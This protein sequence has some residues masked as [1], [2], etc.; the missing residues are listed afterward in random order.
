MEIG[1]VSDLGLDD[2][3]SN[4]LCREISFEEILLDETVAQGD[5]WVLR[6]TLQSVGGINYRLEAKKNYELLIRIAQKYKVLQT[7]WE[8]FR[9]NLPETGEKREE[10]WVCLKAETG[11]FGMQES[12]KTDCYLIGRYKEK[13]LSMGS[14]DEAV[15]SV[16]SAGG[17]AA[18]QYLE[19]MLTRTKE[20]Y[21]I[22]DCTQPILIYKGNDICYHMLDIFAKELGKALEEM[23]QRV[24][25]FDFSERQ[26]E[27]LIA[28]KERRFKAVAGVQTHLF[29][30]RERNGNF[31]HDGIDAPQYHFVFDHPVWLQEHLQQVPHR[32]CV[33]APDG[34]Y[35]QF[36]KN[37][38]GHAARFLPP[39][40]ENKD[41]G[42]QERK[43]E[44]SFL[45]RCGVEP[46]KSLWSVKKSSRDRCRLINRYILYMRKNLSVTPECAFQMAL[47]YYGITCTKEEFIKLFSQERW[48]IHCIA[49]HYKNKTVETLLKAGIVVHV[50]GESWEES[51][52]RNHPLLR[53]HQG[54][55][56]TEALAVYAQSK[57]SLNVMTWHKDGF[58][59]RIANA[60][61]QKSVV[62]TDRTTYLE[63]EFTDGE[64]ILLFDLARLTELPA[65]IK[66]LLADDVRRKQI[67]ENG[68]RIAAERHTW[69]QRAKA[70]LGFVEEDRRA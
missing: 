15:L 30:L 14:F 26:P 3:H 53:R 31:L 40:G 6:E 13:L 24:E 39:A 44:I 7:N 55:T 50:Y 70:L 45:G 11:A 67:A 18:V 35:V 21:D 69:G 56:E 9:K 28:Y 58:T 27:E 42:E 38:Y 68:Y 29:S 63:K 64:D 22:Y 54:V 43:Y 8:T 25:Y 32:L 52:L 33:L 48:V 47:D 57:L 61:L 37:Y 60:M 2:I 23:G 12:V 1:A 51:D 46:V 62:V 59:E 41:V 19:R 17:E 10:E 34:N 66:E 16:Y 4:G 5:I 49:N 20:F 36:I 65:R